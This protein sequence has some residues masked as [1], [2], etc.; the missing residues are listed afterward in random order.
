MHGRG[1]RN[2]AGEA[3]AR[4]LHLAP[5]RVPAADGWVPS[6]DGLR[7]VSIALVMAAHLVSDKLAPGGFGVAVF[8]TISGFL[9]ARLLL[10][11]HKKRGR[12][13]LAAFYKRRMLRLYPAMAGYVAIVVAVY[14][15]GG[16]PV[17]WG[18]VA[19]VLTYVAN[20][21]YVWADGAGVRTLMPFGVFWSLAVEE[22][23]Y[24]LFPPLLVLLGAR[25]RRLLVAVALVCAGELAWRGLAVRLDPRLAG[26][27]P[28]GYYRT[29]FRLDS[30]AWGVGLAVLCEMERGRALIRRLGGAAPMLAALALLVVTFAV[31]GEGFRQTWRYSLQGLALT[32]LFCGLLFSG[33]WRLA[34]IALNLPAIVWVGRLSY[35]LYIWHEATPAIADHLLP[36][37]PLPAQWAA[38][39]GLSF[40]LAAASYYGLEKPFLRLRRRYGS[41]TAYAPAAG[42]PVAAGL[43][44][45]A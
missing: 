29:D 15:A 9:I 18:E 11:E 12:V 16:R 17:G 24:L 30:L 39:L 23:F 42:A 6:L 37:A 10:A 31:R 13:D 7:A 44:E 20:Y 27:L 36:G 8:F 3:R 4:P 1:G 26:P 28:L 32:T 41:E 35:S 22:H 45:P 5:G 25:P 21:F 40:A 38:R 43:P 33:R 19:A 34:Q 14:L 2:G